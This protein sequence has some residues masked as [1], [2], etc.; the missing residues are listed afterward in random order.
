MY[1]CDEFIFLSALLATF[2]LGTAATCTTQRCRN[3][4]SGGTFYRIHW[5]LTEV[6]QDIP[7]NASKVILGSNNI[8]SLPA[9]VFKHLTKCIELDMRYNRISA[10]DKEAFTGMVSLHLLALTGNS[11]SVIIAGTFAP[12]NQ[13][14]VLRLD[15]NQISTMMFGT[16]KGLHFLHQLSLKHNIIFFI[17]AEAFHSLYALRQLYLNKNRLITLKPDLFINQPCPFELV[18]SE[19]PGYRNDFICRSLCWLKHEEQHGT[20]TWPDNMFPRCSDNVAWLSLLCGN[21]GKLFSPNH[22]GKL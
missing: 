5:N 1:Q 8:T 10:I 9:G 2:V 20:I 15:D 3:E 6:P 21:P 14:R 18:L 12:L 11:L 19:P 22:S 16:F 7:N 13:L 17:E 4:Y